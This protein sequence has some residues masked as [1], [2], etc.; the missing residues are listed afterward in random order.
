M[1]A[2][3]GESAPALVVGIGNPLRSDDGLGWRVVE[4]L[5]RQLPGGVEAVAVHQLTP[6]LALRLSEVR[7]A[8]FIDAAVDAA[9]G[10]LRV[11][12]LEP[13]AFEPRW[14]HDLDPAELLGLV[15]RLGQPPPVARIFTVGAGSLEHGESLTPEVAAVVDE[16]CRRVLH[17]FDAGSAR[18]AHSR[19]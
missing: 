8:V 16:L 6:E 15:V 10:E 5:Q 7:R 11:R 14:T 4:R 17:W 1:S 3:G 9:A 19:T 2:S 12:D 18:S 13:R